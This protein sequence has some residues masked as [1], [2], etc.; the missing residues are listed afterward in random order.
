MRL[1]FL[2]KDIYIVCGAGHLNTVWKNTKGLTSVDG[3][4]LALSNMFDTPKDDMMFFK[5]DDSGITVDPHPQS[6]VRSD[7]RVFYLI[8]KATVDCLG[9]SHLTIAAQ[10]FQHA[11]QKNI[12]ASPIT[13]EWIEMDDLFIFMQPLISRSTVE[14]ICG[15]KFLQQFPEFVGDFW[16]FNRRVPKL[17]QGWPRCMMPKAWQARDRCIETMKI[18]RK[19]CNED[20]DGNAMI[21]RR[22]SYFSRMKG[23]SEHGVACS[24]LGILWG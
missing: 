14:A 19:L 8:H 21:L 5:A 4:N 22:W 11:L 13:D 10:N 18:W 3:L 1:N 23:L 2:T 17:L 9:G 12:E 15:P 20:F 24:D 6:S 16:N 7:D